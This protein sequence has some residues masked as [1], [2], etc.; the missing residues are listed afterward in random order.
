MK[1]DENEL[2]LGIE[3]YVLE[4]NWNSELVQNEVIFTFRAIVNV[5]D[6]IVFLSIT[7]RV[8]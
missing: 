6:R 8:Q 2:E 1:K 4:L 7:V 3:H 5:K